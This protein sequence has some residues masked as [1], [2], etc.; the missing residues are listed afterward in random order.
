MQVLSWIWPEVRGWRILEAH[1]CPKWV[2]MR[3]HIG[4]RRPEAPEDAGDL[5][6]GGW[7]QRI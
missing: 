7:G 3:V 4:E 2:G 5:V 1:G 6:L